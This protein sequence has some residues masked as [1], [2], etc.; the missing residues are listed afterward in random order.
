MSITINTNLSSLVVQLS[1]KGSTIDLN[2]AIERMT[3]GYKINSAKDDAAG[4]AV[5]TGM[6][7]QLGAYRVAETNATTGLD[8]VS[9]AVNT[10]DLMSNQLSRLRSLA[11]QAQN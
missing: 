7:T 11:V 4:Y 6:N 2:R 5:V 3:T 9:T 8:M 1:M 10:L